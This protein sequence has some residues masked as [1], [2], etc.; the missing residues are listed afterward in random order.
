MKVDATNESASGAYNLAAPNALTNAEMMKLISK[1]AG[2]SFGLPAYKWMLEVGAFFMRTETEL[3]LKS[4][5]VYPERLLEEGF[6][7]E[8][9]TF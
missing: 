4:R 5:W 6:V 2:V 7:F 9:E 1:R 3:I 8:E